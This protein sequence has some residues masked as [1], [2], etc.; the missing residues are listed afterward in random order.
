MSRYTLSFLLKKNQISSI[1]SHP[2]KIRSFLN[3]KQGGLVRRRRIKK[4]TMMIITTM[5]E[6][7][8]NLLSK[9]LMALSKEEGIQ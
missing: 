1:I 5:A 9:I 4:I 8:S 2:K 7:F 3:K 6:D